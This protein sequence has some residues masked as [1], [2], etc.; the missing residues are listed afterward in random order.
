MTWQVSAMAKCHLLGKLHVVPH[1]F[2]ILLP[3]GFPLV[4][5]QVESAPADVPP[6]VKGG[7]T[8]RTAKPNLWQII[9]LL[10]EYYPLQ[11]LVR[12]P[13]MKLCPGVVITKFSLLYF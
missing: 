6:G 10:A 7:S 2:G 3:T 8:I 4:F 5:E 9:V 1:R 11:L 13:R 12:S